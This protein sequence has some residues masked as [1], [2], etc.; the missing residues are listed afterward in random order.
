MNHPP[1]AMSHTPPALRYVTCALLLVFSLA[2][3]YAL[4]PRFVSQIYYLK[5]RKFQKAGYLGLAV[6]NYNKAADYQPRDANTWQKLAE[7]RLNMGKKKSLQEALLYTLKAKDL[8]LWA[9]RY[10][11]LDAETVYGLA[12]TE[13]RLEQIYQ[14]LNPEEKNNPYDA[15]PYFERAIRLRPNRVTLHYEMA[16]Y[17]FRHDDKE[18]LFQIV[19]STARIYP[20]AYTFLKKERFWSPSVKAAV[21]QGLMDA[22]KQDLS[23]ESAHKVMSS[24]LA[25][26]KEWD[27]SI[28]HYQKALEFNEDNISER[29]YITLGRLYLKNNQ[30]EEAEISF[31]KGLYLSTSIEKS[32]VNISRIYKDGKHIDDYDAFC[33]EVNE[34]WV[35][36]SKMHIVSARYRIDL[37]Q[38]SSAKRILMDLNRETPTAEAYY[39]LARIAEREKDWD[40]MELNIQKAT[41]LEPSNMNYRRMFYGLLKRL[42]KYKT[43]EREIGLMIQY[44]DP[45][46]PAL[47]DERAKLRLKR[48]DY[49]GAVADWKAAIDLAPKQAV[50]HANIA[51]AY[52]KLG[53]VSPALEYYQK[54]IKLNPGNKD[55]AGKYKKLKG[56]SS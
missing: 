24:M 54:A 56:K 50:Y 22:I 42:G 39:W 45:P 1:L 52:I 46:S 48:Q 49:T 8:Y 25:E 9:A 20:S 31:I 21:K 12:R 35:F 10:N 4:Y 34:R 37:K 16:R 17:L 44:S 43:A 38:Y 6:N 53:E 7:A 13:S 2:A 28:V 51:E 33:R 41:V 30:T 23:P 3:V 27:R 36:S 29:D 5:A 11:P 55:Y 32:F 15:L 40:Q 19:R 26:D 14:R 47:F 18:A